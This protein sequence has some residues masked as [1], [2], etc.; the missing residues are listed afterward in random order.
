MTLK[1]KK[2]ISRTAWM[3]FRVACI[4]MLVV[5]SIACQKMGKQAM[6]RKGGPAP[7]FTLKRLDGSDVTLST[8]RGKVVLIE[9]WATWCPPCR[10][11]LPNLQKLYSRFRKSGVRVISVAVK[12]NA[13]EVRNFVE[14][15]GLTFDICMDD[16]AVSRLYDVRGIPALFIVDTE[17]VIRHQLEGYRPSVDEEIAARVEDLL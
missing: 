8:L 16:D 11:S 5:G 17:G 2:E 7:E 6:A 1:T 4:L 12:D 14:K 3:I 10:E 9:F 15:E 13:A